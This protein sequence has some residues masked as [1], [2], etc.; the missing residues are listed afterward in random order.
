M[1]ITIKLIK[2]SIDADHIIKDDRRIHSE[3][4]D[5]VGIFYYKV[6]RTNRPDWV[7]DFFLGRLQCSDRFKVA[8]AAGVLLVNRRYNGTNRTFAITFGLGRYILQDNVTEERFG[9]R[10]ALNSIQYDS[11]RSI[12]FNK[13][14]GIPSIVR[15]QVSRLTRIENFNINT[16]V[17]LLKSI[18]GKLPDERQTEIGTSMTGADSLTI[19]SDITVNNV[20]NKLD[21]LY[22]LY[23]SE[24]YKQHFSWVDN[25][26]AIGD[27]VLR[28]E[29]DQALFDKINA[30]ETDCIWMVLPSIVEWAGIAYLKYSGRN[31][32]KHDDVGI[33]TALAEL[34][35][36]RED[37]KAIDFKTAKVKAYDDN[38]NR[39]KEWLLY[40]CLYGELIRNGHQYILNDGS[41]YLVDQ[42]F[43][44]E[45]ERIS[46]SVS[47]SD[48]HFIPW[49]PREEDG[50]E[51]FE[52]EKIYNERLA[53]SD[54]RLC[55]MDR[56]LVYP[57]GN[58]DKIEFC[59]VYGTEG[60]IIH[61]KRAGGSELIGHLLNQGLVS[62][63]LLL[64]DEFRNKLNTKLHDSNRDAWSVPQ[65]RADFNAGNYSIIYG[66]MSA[67]EGD[68]L[69][70][71]FFSKVI[72]REVVGT[73]R[74]YGYRVFINKICKSRE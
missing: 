20:I 24:A 32:N 71:P 61:V 8:S 35:E 55:N 47:P 33:D 27:N 51:R 41:W 13:M 46:Q 31:A 16:Q 59:D 34:F 38:G 43:Y 23:Q 72:L 1:K 18:T 7:D 67:T 60:Q 29:L 63:T 2:A 21:Q 26:L 69:K 65:R 73:L 62:G 68:D 12:D 58:M 17:N 56:D 37:I 45:I 40:Q 44:A 10:I 30:R 64:T 22:G 14:D 15:N 48:V 54:E 57:Q 66:I 6:S 28:G 19:S 25:I 5:D 50:E 4:I 11:L 53:G 74:S 3:A 9:L 42:N 39:I 36:G 70:L 52:L 49:R